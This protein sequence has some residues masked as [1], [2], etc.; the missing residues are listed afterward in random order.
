VQLLNLY[1]SIIWQLKSIA[2]AAACMNAKHAQTSEMDCYLN[3]LCCLCCCSGAT[4]TEL[5]AEFTRSTLFQVIG[6]AAPAALAA[7]A[8][9]LALMAMS[10]FVQQVAMLVVVE[11]E[12]L[13]C[14]PPCC[15]NKS[16]SSSATCAARH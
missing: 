6:G 1:C 15:N 11:L 10:E 3:S 14:R 9:G 12:G 4:T 13:P 16:L 2:A 8:N 5:A 7:P